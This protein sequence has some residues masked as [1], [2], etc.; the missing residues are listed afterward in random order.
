MEMK[1]YFLNHFIPEKGVKKTVRDNS[2]FDEFDGRVKYLTDLFED[3]E[4]DR[5]CPK[6]KAWRDISEEIEFEEI[7]NNENE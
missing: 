2:S 1:E 7:K 3:A 5:V 6:T 4:V